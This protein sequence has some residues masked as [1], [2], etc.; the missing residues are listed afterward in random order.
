MNAI[1][2]NELTK[3]YGSFTAVDG[4]SFQVKKERCSDYLEPTARKKAL[5]LN[6]F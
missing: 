2:V 3:S 4:L 1:I 5:L 6:V